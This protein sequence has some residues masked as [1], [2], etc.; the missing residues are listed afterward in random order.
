MRIAALATCAA[1]CVLVSLAGCAR[2][3]A[4][5]TRLVDGSRASPPSVALD[6]PT[7]QISTKATAARIST[8]S[9]SGLVGRCV[10]TAAE[11]A[12][13]GRAIVRVAATGLSV[14]YRSGSALRACDGDAGSVTSRRWCGR[15][16]GRLAQGRL[17]DPRLDLAA[18]RT[19]EGAPVAFAWFEPG[20]RS[21]YV[22]VRQPGYAE[23][24]PVVRGLPVRI[25]ITTG[26]DEATS[27][28]RLKVSE[29]DSAGRMLRSST[30]HARVSG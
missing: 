9:P 22:A 18:C 11:P 17:L 13:H 20:P 10:A 7:P 15:A 4:A 25:S 8:A 2:D 26:I 16:Y 19:P 21:S 5:P 30:F 1:V 6:A 24:Y 28:V 23:I 12:R 14:T 29:H 27:T 3:D